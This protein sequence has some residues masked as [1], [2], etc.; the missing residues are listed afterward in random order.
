MMKMLTGLAH[1]PKRRGTRWGGDDAVLGTERGGSLDGRRS[2]R[3][4]RRNWRL[5]REWGWRIVAIFDNLAALSIG[6]RRL[7]GFA[8]RQLVDHPDALAPSEP[9]FAA[10]SGSVG[11][12]PPG[13]LRRVASTDIDGSTPTEGCTGAGTRCGRARASSRSRGGEGLRCRV[14]KELRVAKAQ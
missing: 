8:S 14:R 11:L 9:S 5:G 12:P 4:R 6:N 1:L 2:G 7:L 13:S 3:R 10:R